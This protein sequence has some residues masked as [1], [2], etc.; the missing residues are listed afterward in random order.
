[1]RLYLAMIVFLLGIWQ[2]GEGVWIHA[3]A[4]LAQVLIESAWA[5]TLEDKLTH[6][7]WPWADTWPVARMTIAD[8]VLYTLE[9]AQGN[10]LAFGPGHLQGSVLPGRQGISIV[11]GHRDTHFGF[12]EHIKNGQEIYIEHKEGESRFTVQQI[13]IRDSESEL[14]RFDPGED[15]IVLV[16][17]YP[18]DALDAGGSLRYVVTARRTG[19]DN[20]YS[21]GGKPTENLLAS[22][23]SKTAH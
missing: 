11:G 3:K 19:S 16:T 13:S 21:A 12:L 4:Q 6:K 10:S 15:Q 1:M 23:V 8:E 5:A 20:R 9:G 18:F 22:T 2:I 14:L 17:C 7:P